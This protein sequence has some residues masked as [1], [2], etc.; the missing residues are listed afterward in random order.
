AAAVISGDRTGHWLASEA[1]REA[2]AALTH[3]TRV[4]T[5]GEVTAS[6][7]HE[8]NQP[9]AAI[10]NN[11]NACLGLLPSGRHGLDEVREALA[12]I[13]SDADRASAIIERVRGLAK[14]TPPEKVPLRLVDVVD[15][16]VTLAA[17]ESVARRVAIRTD[18]AADRSEEHTSE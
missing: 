18:V 12:D 13:V 5:L 3:V 9:L 16:V 6:F 10:V 1:L 4:T 7:A 2:Q 11:A 15:D 17:A 8:L 14:R